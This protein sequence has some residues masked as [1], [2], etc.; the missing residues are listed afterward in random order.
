VTN[1][2]TPAGWYEDPTKIGE[3]RYH[4][5]ERWTEF[6]TID[7]VQTTAAF[8]AAPRPDADTG[9]DDGPTFTMYR[10]AQWRTE[11][12]KPLEVVGTAG[13]I[14]GQFET[15]ID[16]TPGYRFD[17]VEGDTVVTLAKPSLKNAVEVRDPAG[18]VIGTI[19]KVG[20]LRSRYD[21]AVTSDGRRASLKLVGGGSDE[22]E[23]QLAGMQAATMTRTIRSVADTLN[24]A[25][26]TYSAT[27]ATGLDD[28]MERIVLV[29]PLAIDVL[30]TQ[31]LAP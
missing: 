29:L 26:V 27:V 9:A 24:F 11:Q 1:L 21:V 19:A 3:L 8:D 7:G 28:H 10:L 4:D 31:A 30:D 17:D 6:V 18:D 23:L 12:E 16:G 13:H 20:R 2:G 22:W 14:L 15:L 5:G 25:G